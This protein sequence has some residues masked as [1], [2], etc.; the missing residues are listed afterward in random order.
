[1]NCAICLKLIY[2]YLDNELD[3]NI[4]CRFENHLENCN[5]C[6][7]ELTKVKAALSLY[8]EWGNSNE[9]RSDFTEVVLSKFYTPQ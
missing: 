7:L 5:D 9:I 1:M 6:C 2:D 4:R 8:Q 3:D